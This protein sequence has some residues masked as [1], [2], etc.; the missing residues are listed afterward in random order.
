M[1][2]YAGWLFLVTVAAMD[3]KVLI[4]WN[5]VEALLVRAGRRQ[6]WLAERMNVSSNVVTNWKS[7]G[8]VPAGRAPALAR[9]F[10]MS[11]GELLTADLDGAPPLSKAGLRLVQKIGEMDRDGLL[12]KQTE[13]ALMAVLDLMESAARTA[14]R[15]ERG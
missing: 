15:K 1:P 13:A 10:G 8:G 2:L 12:T 14:Q 5:R 11:V 9:V 6:A 7:R 4:P 3:E